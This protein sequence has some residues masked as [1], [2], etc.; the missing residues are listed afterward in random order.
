MKQ[1]A[2]FLTYQPCVLLSAGWELK[3]SFYFLQTLSS[4]F[5]DLVLVG[6]E[7]QEF[8]Q[9]QY[10]FNNWCSINGRREG[11]NSSWIL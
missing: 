2:Q 3:P 8:G 9:Q 7:G 5:F 11:T 4:Y 6:R 10:L 1:G